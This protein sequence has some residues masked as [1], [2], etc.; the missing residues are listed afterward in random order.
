[1]KQWLQKKA[2][3]PSYTGKI[4]RLLE[5][6]KA[7]NLI[8]TQDQGAGRLLEDIR[9]AHLNQEGYEHVM[10][11]LIDM[12]E[13]RRNYTGF[14]RE[15]GRQLGYDFK[16]QG[17]YKLTNF[18]ND[19]TQ[20]VAHSNNPSTVYLLLDH[21]DAILDN[22]NIDHAY[23]MDFFNNLN[24]MR[25]ANVRLVCVTEAPHDTSLVFGEGKPQGVST[26]TL[27]KD[28]L[29]KLSQT[30]VQH[31]WERLC[32]RKHSYLEPEDCKPYR[33]DIQKH[34]SAYTFLKFVFDRLLYPEEGKEQAWSPTKQLSH[35]KSLYAKN[36][37]IGGMKRLHK[38]MNTLQKIKIVTG[39]KGFSVSQFIGNVFR[40]FTRSGDK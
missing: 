3:R 33:A 24:A 35:W 20:L 29:R 30:E 10:V 39:L 8:G 22:P 11:V 31:E 18:I 15:L 34:L 4:I 27:E 40:H 25:H 2:L 19:A 38:G 23:N 21:F 16:L 12:L 32:S 5:Q 7:V 6:G 28:Y 37:H 26:L 17:Q 36:K 13:Y 1:M 14:K 9:D